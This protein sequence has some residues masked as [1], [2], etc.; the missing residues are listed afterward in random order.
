MSINTYDQGDTVPCIGTFTL[1]GSPVDP[2]DVTFHLRG[3]NLSLSYEYG[4]D[5]ELVKVSAGVYRVDFPIPTSGIT[6]AGRW[7]YRFEGTGANGGAVEARFRVR[8]S[9]IY[10]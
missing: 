9:D 10:G 3:P 5:A 1:E 6:V 8:N 7:S 4:V 2:D